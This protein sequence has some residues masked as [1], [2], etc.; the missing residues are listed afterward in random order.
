MDTLSL[1]LD[2]TLIAGTVEYDGQTQAGTPLVT[3]S[4][5]V[6]FQLGASLLHPWNEDIDVYTSLNYHLWRRG[7][8]ASGSVSGLNELYQ[9]WNL[10]AGVRTVVYKQEHQ[11]WLVDVYAFHTI[12]P[13]IDVDLGAQGLG[14]V[15]LSLGARPGIR[16]EAILQQV[17]FDNAE[18]DIGFYIEAWNFGR[19]NSKSVSNGSSI[20]TV[21]EPRSETRN[22][23]VRLMFNW[24][25]R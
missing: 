22:V 15:N 11:T 1:R 9:W 6:M 5:A 2:T 18:F 19:S 8:R 3:R 25:F 13:E 21:T 20:I 23:G 14:D 10:G 17:R 16:A 4:D 7:I 24:M 12:A